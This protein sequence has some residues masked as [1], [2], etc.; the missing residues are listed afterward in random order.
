M[1]EDFSNKYLETAISIL[2]TTI[3]KTREKQEE[4]Q[5]RKEAARKAAEEEAAEEEAARKAAEEEELER[6]K[7]E[8][9]EAA[10]RKQEEAERKK[11]EEAERKKK[12][13]EEAARKAEQK[14]IEAARKAEQKR[15][16]AARKADKKEAV[17]KATKTKQF[18]ENYTYISPPSKKSSQSTSKLFNNKNVSSSKAD[19]NA[20]VQGNELVE[21]KKKLEAQIEKLDKKYNGDLSNDK[22]SDTT[23]SKIEL[24]EAEQKYKN[25]IEK[26]QNSAKKKEK[27]LELRLRKAEE[28]NQDEETRQKEI[29]R[30]TKLIE[31]NN[32]VLTKIKKQQA[33]L[34]GTRSTI[35]KIFINMRKKEKE[36]FLN[37]KGEALKKAIESLKNN[38]NFN[39]MSEIKIEGIL[40]EYPILHDK[41]KN[42]LVFK[43]DELIKAHHAKF[44]S[45]NIKRNNE[46]LVETLKLVPSEPFLGIEGL[47]LVS[48]FGSTPEKPTEKEKEIESLK[49][50][51]K[52]VRDFIKGRVEYIFDLS[53][54]HQLSVKEYLKTL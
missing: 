25:E 36:N 27:E 14:R 9:E 11:Q 19:L 8:E 30:L 7:K 10:R 26:L 37:N 24:H 2:N 5:K 23:T 17:R 1:T 44:Y 32:I 48:G 38:E 31:K 33:D 39:N 29:E 41:I 12:E 13:E 4:E 35:E 43:E 52:D 54:H 46:K 16:E 22:K 45:D 50:I 15:I 51:K 6:K 21:S 42:F 53:Q 34:E 49:E 40:F 47:D 18:I 28:S 3:G 20:P